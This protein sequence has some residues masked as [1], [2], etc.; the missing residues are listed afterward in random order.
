MI[1]KMDYI[2]VGLIGFLMA[3]FFIVVDEFVTLV[4]DIIKFIK[5]N[6]G[7]QK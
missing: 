4:I 7:K 2:I 6:R 3:F 1:E 5:R